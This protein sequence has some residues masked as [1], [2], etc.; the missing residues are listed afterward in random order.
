MAIGRVIVVAIGTG[1]VGFFHGRFYLA[2]T[3]V[4]SWLPEHLVHK[5]D[6]ITVGSIHNFS[7]LGGGL[8]LIVGIVYLVRVN[9]KIRGLR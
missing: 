3:G 1:V 4:D 2:R 5:A 6:F 8:G 9:W 7:Y